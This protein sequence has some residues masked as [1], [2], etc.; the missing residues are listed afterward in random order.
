MKMFITP[1]INTRERVRGGSC[2][3]F[4]FLPLFII[5]SLYLT[6]GVVMAGSLKPTDEI[7][8]TISLEKRVAKWMSQ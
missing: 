8:P 2:T 3:W 6:K 5:H 1:K 7:L 4:C